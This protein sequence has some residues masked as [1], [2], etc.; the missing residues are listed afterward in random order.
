M[1]RDTPKNQYPYPSLGEATTWRVMLAS[2]DPVAP[3]TFTTA[4]YVPT[5]QPAAGGVAVHTGVLPLPRGLPGAE[6]GIGKGS[7]VPAAKK[8]LGFFLF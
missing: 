3:D 8:I 5:G 7:N 2:L 6:L 4:T 1:Y